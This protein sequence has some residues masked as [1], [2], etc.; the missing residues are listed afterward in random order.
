LQATPTQLV[1]GRGMLFNLKKVIN[2]KAITENKRK[3]ID[4][5]NER[6][7]SARINYTY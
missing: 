4:R 6:E 7:N 2:W 5:D 1:F 3:Q